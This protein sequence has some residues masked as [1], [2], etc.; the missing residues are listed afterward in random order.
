MA[1]KKELVTREMLSALF[2]IDLELTDA[3]RLFSFVVTWNR[4]SGV[5]GIRDMGTY[6]VI[7]FE[8][9]RRS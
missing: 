6:I 1:Q 9:I 5:A 2:G 8:G 7:D 3:P 4:A